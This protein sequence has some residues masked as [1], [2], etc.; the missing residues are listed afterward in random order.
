MRNIARGSDREANTAQGE[1]KC[2]I[3]LETIPIFPVVHKRKRYFNW[4]I[5]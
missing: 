4:F 1:A 3:S 2:Y 5:L